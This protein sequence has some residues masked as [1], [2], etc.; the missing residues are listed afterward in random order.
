M[1]RRGFK[2]LA[3]EWAE[4]WVDEWVSDLVSLI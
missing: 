4:V 1:G 3:E 2:V